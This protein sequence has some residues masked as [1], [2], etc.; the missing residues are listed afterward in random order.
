MNA[1]KSNGRSFPFRVEVVEN[2]PQSES[3]AA[4]GITGVREVVL[5]ASGKGGVGK[6]TVAVNL[7]CALS[8]RDRRVGV[9]DVDLY[10][11][12]VARM[13]G[14]GGHPVSYN[15]EGRVVPMRRHGVYCLSAGSVLPPEASLV[16]KGPLITQTV[17]QLIYDTAWP[18][19]DLLLV[20]LPPGT[21]DIP[22]TLLERVPISGAAVVTTPQRLAVADADRA[23]T[24]F[25]QRDIP[26]F[27]VIEN[28]KGYVCPCCGELQSLFPEGELDRLLRRR[29]IPYLGGIPLSP[30]GQDLIDDGV[31]LVVA[32]PEGPVG[33]AFHE[34][35][36]LVEAALER[37]IKIRERD[38]DEHAR[39]QHQDFWERLLD[40]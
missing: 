34:S 18:D 28:M 36:A 5:V 35:A 26:V 27:G 22:L 9:L 40:D 38:R 37:E 14:V 23:I 25:H 21:G 24:M 2:P 10:G 17:L 16:W 39:Q 7:G 15:D 4:A 31:P 33:R 19:L 30:A 20:D 32:D 8:M 6:S 1:T 12:S 11:P 3:T 13:L 29:H